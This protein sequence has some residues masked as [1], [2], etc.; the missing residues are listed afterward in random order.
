M[1]PYNGFSGDLRSKVDH[2]QKSAIAAGVM[3][4]R[5]ACEL[6][7]QEGAHI[8]LHNED[9]TK[10]L[11]GAHPICVECHMRLHRRFSM[12]NRWLNHL[13]LLRQGLKGGAYQS[14]WLYMKATS[15]ETADI[16]PVD[17]TPR[18]GVWWENLPMERIDFNTPKGWAYL[19]GVPVSPFIEIKEQ[20][21]LPL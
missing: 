1:N 20:T 16:G 7:G 12:P 4:F 19:C 11:E 18:D 9:Y 8:Q 5:R 17:F 6:C 13:L 10:P 3:V 15:G 2:I 14:P 21:C